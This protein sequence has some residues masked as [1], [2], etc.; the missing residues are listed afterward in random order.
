MDTFI[1][2]VFMLMNLFNSINCRVIVLNKINVFSSLHHN[3]I[4]LIVLGGEFLFQQWMI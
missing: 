2:H 3:G 4:F 1:F